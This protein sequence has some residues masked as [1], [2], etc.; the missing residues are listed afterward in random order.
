MMSQSEQAL[1]TASSNS[2]WSW[3]SYLVVFDSG[4]SRA[5]FGPPPPPPPPQ[6]AKP[7]PIT[8]A[9]TDNMAPRAQLLDLDIKH[10]LL[11]CPLY[12][13]RPLCVDFKSFGFTHAATSCGEPVGASTPSPA[14]RTRA[15]APRSSARSPSTPATT[16]TCSAAFVIA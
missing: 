12:H 8:S 6:A 4:R 16:V 7:S 9:A 1:F 10:L 14:W 3:A 13:F 5:I 15:S 2:G 11:S